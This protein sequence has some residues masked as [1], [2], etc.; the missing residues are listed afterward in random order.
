MPAPRYIGKPCI[1]GHTGERYRSNNGCVEC[2]RAHKP[3]ERGP[4]NLYMR[5]YRGIKRELVKEFGRDRL[6]A[7]D[8]PGRTP[9]GKAQN[10]AYMRAKRDER[11]Q[12]GLPRNAWQRTK[13]ANREYMRQWRASRKNNVV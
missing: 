11:E 8:L 9:R 2:L 3:V 7:N 5:E 6:G 10:A 1:H 4:R 12:A 13:E